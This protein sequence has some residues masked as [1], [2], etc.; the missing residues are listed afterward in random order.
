MKRIFKGLLLYRSETGL[1]RSDCEFLRTY[2]KFADGKSRRMRMVL[3]YI[4]LFQLDDLEIGL[5][6][7]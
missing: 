6:F 7:A 1:S 5:S 3:Y 2:W 4:Y